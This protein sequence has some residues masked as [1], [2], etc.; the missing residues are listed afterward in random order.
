MEIHKT[1]ESLWQNSIR[2]ATKKDGTFRISITH[3]YTCESN[4][5]GKYL[6]N[7]VY[8][9][10]VSYMN[11]QELYQSCI[12]NYVF[13]IDLRTQE[14]SWFM[15]RFKAAQLGFKKANHKLSIIQEDVNAKLGLDAAGKTTILYKLKL[16]D[17]ESLVPIIAFNLEKIQR[18]NKIRTLWKPYFQ[19]SNG[20]I[21]VIDCSDKERMSEA[22]DELYRLLLDTLLL[23]LTTLIY[24]NKQDLSQMS[25]SDLA[26]ELNLQKFAKN[27]HIQ[28]CC[29]ITG[30]GLENGLKWIQVVNTQMKYLFLLIYHIDISISCKYKQPQKQVIMIYIFSFE[31]I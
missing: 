26:S 17:I 3:Y 15:I 10:K 20:L 25:P 30:E 27:W 7:N 19:N 9:I 4:I 6:I 16:G 31:W 14:T 1:K 11:L 13:K 23:G 21:Y 12:Y 29:V 18:A 2:P 28:P 8:D 24:A 5:T 22:K